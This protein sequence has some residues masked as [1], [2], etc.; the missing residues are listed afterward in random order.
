VE[1][2]EA[3]E[4]P[5][6]VGCQFHPEFKSKPLAAHPL[7]AAFIKASVEHRQRRLG[8]GVNAETRVSTADSVN[9]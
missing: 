9:D 6:F 4:H 8:A 1:I 2:V 5:W 3:P 7:F